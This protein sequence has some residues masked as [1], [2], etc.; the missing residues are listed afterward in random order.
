MQLD[1]IIKKNFITGNLIAGCGN[2]TPRFLVPLISAPPLPCPSSSTSLHPLT[3]F[4]SPQ[5]DPCL[6]SP[7][8]SA[9]ATAIPVLISRDA[10][11][12]DQKGVLRLGT[13]HWRRRCHGRGDCCF[14]VSYS[15][16]VLLLFLPHTFTSFSLIWERRHKRPGPRDRQDS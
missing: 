7:S 4:P 15:P 11:S 12:T 13:N 2:A 5:I 10:I 3:Q 16:L 14:L 1:S 9:N 6:C 8:R